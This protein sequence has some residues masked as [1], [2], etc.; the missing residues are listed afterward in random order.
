MSRIDSADENRPDRKEEVATNTVSKSCASPTPLSGEE[1]MRI[2][3]QVVEEAESA[4]ETQI[5]AVLCRHLQRISAASCAAVAS[6]DSQ[7]GEVFLQAVE[8]DP[9]CPPEALREEH[10]PRAL[11]SEQDLADLRSRQI[12]PDREGAF[13]LR[14]LLPAPIAERIRRDDPRRC[15]RLS[16][17]RNGSLLALGM[18]YFAGDPPAS[19]EAV[20]VYLSLAAVLLQRLEK[21][22]ELRR[23]EATYRSLIEATGTG[24]FITDP[25]GHV[26]EANRQYVRMT[27]HSR[28]TEIQGRSVREWTAPNDRTRLQ[29][30]LARCTETEGVHH[31]SLAHQ[32]PDG[33]NIDV[34]IH[35][36]FVRGE[37]E[38]RILA[39][40]TDVSQRKALEA[41]QNQM[42][43]LEAI[44]QLA[45]GIAHEINT[46]TQFV[47]DNLRFLGDSVQNL[48]AIIE[49]QR[50]ELEAYRRGRRLPETAGRQNAFEERANLEYLFEEVPMAVQ[51][52]LEG[53]S[54]VTKIV[55]AMREFSHPGR[56]EIKLVDLNQ[57]LEKALTVCRNEWQYYCSLETDYTYDLPLVPCCADEIN[58]VFLNILVNA[59]HAVREV[60]GNLRKG[61]LRVETRF[62]DPWVEVRIQDSG[63]GIPAAI[64]DKVFL[65]FFTTKEPGKGTGQG[66]A[67][68]KSVV[69]KHGGEISFES[70]EG[71][72]TTFLIRLPVTPPKSTSLLTDSEEPYEQVA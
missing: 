53:V 34:E 6:W 42:M 65:P 16:C 20:D 37:K 31:F 9:P 35:A 14:D 50:E 41:R 27:G 10:P 51:Q 58:Q 17:L 57:T 43:K 52:A 39:L 2:L 32:T 12:L 28:L 36:T 60:V 61:T 63:P 72:G 46:P 19:L 25:A 62:R 21:S 18:L 5:Y 33:R 8:T 68:A 56:G 54:R 48:L 26:R 15:F 13:H 22:R 64:R 55:S 7:T 47:G 30:A 45:A 23:S 59:A 1:A 4:A 3:C 49:R 40:C 67:I 24:Y 38:D 70:E 44:G 29:E 11:V 66:L 69:E 71:K